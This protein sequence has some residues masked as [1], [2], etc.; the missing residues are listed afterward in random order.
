MSE[1]NQPAQEKTEQPTPKRLADARQKGQVPR[2]RELNTM[3]VMLVGAAA[4]LLLGGWMM[5]GLQALLVEYLGTAGMLGAAGRD[6]ADALMAS[7]WDGTRLLLPLM[8]VLM[9]AAVAGPAMLGGAVF[10]AEA[11]RPKLE[12]LSVIK[13]L[14]RIF[15]AQG[16]MELVKTL[17]KFAVLTGLSV[18]LLWGLS[19]ELLSLGEGSVERGMREV[20]GMVQLSFLVLAGGLTLIAAV[21]VPFQLWNH[22]KQ[23]RM[24]RQEVKDELK[25]TEGNPEMRGRIRRM[26][27]EVASRRMMEQVPLADVVITNP[28]HYAVALRY[29]DRPDRAPRVV[30]MGQDLV[31]A[32]IRELAGEH[33]V[34]L[35]E[36]PPL[37]RAIFFNCRLGDEI[38]AAL[39]LAVARVLAWVMQVRT[40]RETGVKV[41]SQPTGLPVPDELLQPRRIR[42]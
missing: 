35:C 12:R 18:A 8:A 19:A 21:D 15:S 22:F 30:A 36:A 4:M 39:Y 34:P 40:A 10:S 20:A 6:P 24:T 9:V 29:S 38:P 32:R 7:V 41:P 23:L 37:A 5:Q 26:Q 25:Q 13:G 3:T 33:R 11:A 28:T 14:Q 16:L 27:H 17:L 2:S 1:N 42:R 31:A